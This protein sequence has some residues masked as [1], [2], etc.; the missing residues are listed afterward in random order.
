[1][2]NAEFDREQVLNAAMAVFI[3]KG[4]GK[5][6]VQDLKAATGLHPGSI[7]CAFDNKRGL[8]IAALE[9]YASARHSSFNQLCQQHDSALGALEAYINDVV[10]ECEGQEIKGCLL[11]KSMAEV[12]AQDEEVEAIISQMFKQWQQDLL[13]LLER[14]QTQGEISSKADCQALN[15]FIIMSIYGM[16]SLSHTKP[17][18]AVL[19]SLSAQVLSHVRHSEQ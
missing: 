19:T 10:K 15:D 14:A 16:R 12:S 3:E 9:H 11:Q 17:T 6:S 7:Y 1:M 13:Q 2:R 4:Y 8:L 18:R 5:T